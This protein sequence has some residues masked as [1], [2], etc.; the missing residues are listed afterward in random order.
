MNAR[1]RTFAGLAGAAGLAVWFFG[2]VSPAG[3]QVARET[4]GAVRLPGPGSGDNPASGA[5]EGAT[6]DGRFGD[7][8]IQSARE[9]MGFDGGK[10][11]VERESIVRG[12]DGKWCRESAEGLV[13]HPAQADYEAAEKLVEVQD[14]GRA[15]SAFKR[16]AQKHKGSALEEDCLF[17]EAESYYRDGRLPTASD[18]Y[19]KLM[20]DFPSTRHLPTA[21]QRMYEISS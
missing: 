7:K 18:T 17:Q 15:A 2:V 3:A 19:H 20:K 14:F 11:R 12:P 1:K 4:D 10:R 16:L 21:V 8:I 13:P 6:S 5:K 9:L